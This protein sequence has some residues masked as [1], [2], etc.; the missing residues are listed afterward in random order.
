MSQK[1]LALALAISA[2]L[3]AGCASNPDYTP[4]QLAHGVKI[5]GFHAN[6]PLK[7]EDFSRPHQIAHAFGIPVN[8]LAPESKNIMS[9]SQQAAMNNFIR[10]TVEDG[11]VVGLGAAAVSTVKFGVSY[12]R[13]E[14][15]EWNAILD[16]TSFATIY[17]AQATALDGAAA[18]TAKAVTKCS[19]RQ[20]KPTP[21]TANSVNGLEIA[22]RSSMPPKG[23]RSLRT[24]LMP[25]V[26]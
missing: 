18:R 9:A 19:L 3:L 6:I 24:M 15:D 17:D 2:S 1:P 5:Q 16:P 12:V 7:S 10:G 4:E 14:F 23:V 13:A 21:A 11:I 22:S 25:P 8:D 20:N 26:K